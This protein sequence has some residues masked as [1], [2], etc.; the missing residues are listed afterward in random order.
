M[1]C[2]PVARTPLLPTIVFLYATLSVGGTK[3][4]Y[5][6]R[7]GRTIAQAVSRRLP[8]AAARVRSQFRSCWICGE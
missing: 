1:K 4:G 6:V 5:N 7:I 3:V 8:T 2:L